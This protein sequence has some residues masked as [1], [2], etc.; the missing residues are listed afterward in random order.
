MDTTSIDQRPGTVS[1]TLDPAAFREVMGHYP[2]GVAVVTGFDGDQPVGMV[3]GTFSSVSM[4][5]PLVAF[6]PQ[7]GSGTYARLQQSAAYCINVLAHDQLALCRTMA[8]PR[9]DKFDDVDWSRSPLGAPVLADAV[10]HIHCR[11]HR[12]V[13][14]GDH[15]IVLCEVEA[16]E[17]SRP[18]TPLLF[19]QGG[20]GGFSP[21]GMSARADA[22]LIAA[23]R[24]GDTARGQVERLAQTLGCEAAALV[25]INPDELTTTV[26]AYGGTSSMVEPLGQRI[27]LIP[28]IGEAYVAGAKPDVVD[29][30]LSK[31]APHD[32]DLVERYRTRLAAV[33]TRGA[34][35]SMVGPHAR[36]DYE[37][38]GEALAEYASGELTPARE[39]AVRSVL[40]Q[41]R[42]FFEDV[43]LEHDERYDVGG[44]VVPVRNPEGDISM[45]L[46]ITQLP[47]ATPGRVVESWVTAVKAA[48]SAVERELALGSGTGRLR[49]YR[50]WYA[51]DFPL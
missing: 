4:D 42:N 10:A 16:M 38:L 1:A 14:A 43:A 19:F 44:I 36:A 3:V 33:E 8:V 37:R 34:A 7:V 45:V 9:D 39:R 11:P 50:E 5:P 2:T 35:I 22:E 27:P 41:T 24:L 31:V 40:A 25:A 20:Y 12:S 28:P 32:P 51:S 21:G 47:P 26:S 15:W 30:W 46:R 6:M 23:V 48:A 18:V 29:R 13:E 49:D 17:V